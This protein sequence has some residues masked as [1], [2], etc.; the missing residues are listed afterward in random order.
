MYLGANVEW[1]QDV[2]KGCFIAHHVNNVLHI[3]WQAKE[4]IGEHE[5]LDF[6]WEK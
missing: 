2:D 5:K 3:G 4:H 1:E 6:L